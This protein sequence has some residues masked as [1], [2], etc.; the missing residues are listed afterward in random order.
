MHSS[1]KRKPVKK[2]TGKKKKKMTPY[3]KGSKSKKGY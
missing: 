3:K 2:S 1:S